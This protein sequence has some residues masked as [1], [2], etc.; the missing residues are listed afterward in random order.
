MMNMKI[1]LTIIFSMVISIANAQ[2]YY[3]ALT[4]VVY[5]NGKT[6]SHNGQK[7]QFVRRTS[8]YGAK[9]CFDCT[10]NGRNHLNGNLYFVTIKNDNEIYKGKSYFGENST[11]QFNDSK[12]LM[13]AVDA[14]GYIYVFKRTNA[15]KGRTRSSFLIAGAAQDGWDPL[16]FYGGVPPSYDDNTG[17]SN[18]TSG[19]NS[20]NNQTGISGSRTCGYCKGGKRVRAHVGVST[21]G[22]NNSKKKCHTCGEWYDPSCD[23]WHD[24][25]SCKGAGVR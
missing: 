25:P 16:D 19:G 13:N 5:P 22:V 23:H 14:K 11:Y 12:G 17:N 8:E 1:V 18:S 15:P 4:K 21:F 2:T 10:S 24:C 9:M 7:G 3:Y 6:V 20:N